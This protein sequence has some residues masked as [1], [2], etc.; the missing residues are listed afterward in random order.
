MILVV[1][2]G[3]CGTSTVARLLH[4]ELG[5]SMGERFDPPCPANP[6]GI[7]EDLE[8]REIHVAFQR[9]LLT[10]PMLRARFGA[11]VARRREPWGLKDPRL[12]HHLGLYLQWLEKPDVIWCH[13]DLDSV[14]TSIN[15][16]Y[17]TPV[18][19]AHGESL[20]RWLQLQ[21]V[22]QPHPRVLKIYFDTRRSEGDLAGIIHR[23]LLPSHVVQS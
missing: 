20:D 10:L 9:G 3:R 18:N 8:F 21:R 7:Y 5:I 4:E 16:W 11:L 19:K 17:H 12:A 2:T 22:L 6:D 14:A 15:R 23:W 1:G 13:R